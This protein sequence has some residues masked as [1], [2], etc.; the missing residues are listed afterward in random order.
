M[1]VI[2]TVCPA[3]RELCIL[4]E[5]IGR[6]HVIGKIA[7]IDFRRNELHGDIIADA[8]NGNGGVLT[9]F[10]GNTVIKTVIQPFT[11]KRFSGMLFGSF[12]TFQGDTIDA[13]VE[14]VL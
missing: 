1:A 4:I 14:G 11:G 2:M 7:D 12:I 6:I 9:D 13:A 10:A 3:D 8:V 5:D